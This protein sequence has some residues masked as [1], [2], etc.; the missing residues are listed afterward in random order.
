MNNQD[1]S[2]TLTV[3]QLRQRYDLD[4]MLKDR[5]AIPV[6]KNSLT[7][8]DAE[9]DSILK[10]IIINLGETLESQSDIQL[11]FFDGTPTLENQPAIDWNNDFEAHLGDIYY[12]KATGLVYIF[13]FE[14]DTYF[15]QNKQDSQLVQAMALTN[16]ELEENDDLRRVF[17]TIPKVPYECGDWYINNGDLYICQK[18]KNIGETYEENDFIIAPKYTD[19]TKANETAGK[20]T[21]VAGQVTTIIQSLDLISQTIEDNRYYIDENGEKHLISEATSQLVQS[22]N[23]IKA[24]FQVT[25]GNNLIKNSVGLFVNNYWEELEG[26]TYEYG[27]DNNLISQTTSMSKISLRNGKITSSTDN[28]TGLSLGGIKSLS[29]KINQDEDVTT[30]ITLYGLDITHPLYER[31]F[32]GK[33][34]W[35]NVY[36]ENINKFFIDSPNLTLIIESESIYNGKVSIS[37]L[38]L[39]DGEKQSWQPASGE[40]WG[41]VIKMS[42][43]GISCYSLNDGYITMMTNEGFQIRE[44]HGDTIGKL[45]SKFTNLGIITGEIEQTGKH[46]QNKLV[47]DFIT[48]NNHEVYVEYIKE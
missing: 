23:S 46:I 11:W 10:S 17:F 13:S 39:N 32:Q 28:I 40:I 36:D 37:D 4:G 15:W 29:F 6:I 2:K 41:T 27:E 14:N 34:E 31:S 18:T 25:G 47:H 33:Y 48:S 3:E 21:I 9:N 45:I 44:L 8:I 42:Q 12:D 16:A 19:D 1:K 35:A 30:N 7:R 38:M 24:S 5:K 22:V 43:L 20:L 26:G